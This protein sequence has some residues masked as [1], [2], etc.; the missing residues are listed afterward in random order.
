MASYPEK[1]DNT[2]SNESITKGD[3]ELAPRGLPAPVR[4]A[5]RAGGAGHSRAETIVIKVCRE[6]PFPARS[7]CDQ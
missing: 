3:A 1:L 4:L 6:L 5:R 2:K 7:P